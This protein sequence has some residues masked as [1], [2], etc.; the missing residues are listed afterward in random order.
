MILA[1]DIGNTDIVLGGVEGEKVVFEARLRTEQA[2]TADE[3]CIDMKTLL[4]IYGVRADAFEGAIVASVVPQVLNSFR[5]AIDRLLGKP[6]LVLG[7]G[8][9]TGVNLRI[10]N[11]AQTG[12]DIVA[13]DVAALRAHKPPLI[14]VNM[15]TATTLSVLDRDGAHIGGCMC[16]GV[17]I[18][19]DALTEKAALL[20]R[21]RLDRPRRV[22]GRN[23]VD[24]MRSG[25]LYGAA[26][27]LDG[28]VARIEA[29]LGCRTTVV[30]TGAMAEFVVPLCE[31]Q[32]VFER[33][34]PLRGLAAIYRDNRRPSAQSREE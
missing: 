10:E 14:V 30:A 7:P 8:L 21:L 6:C 13:A 19:A 24:A 26:C 4:D 16:P 29:E 18:G 9:R 20:P 34:L 12:A 22:I 31:R 33:D 27:M 25:I 32:I 2:K 3:Y 28:L 1:A 11:P 15:G 5:A 23:T 17:R